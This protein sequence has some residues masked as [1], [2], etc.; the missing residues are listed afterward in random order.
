VA[1]TP[2]N[3]HLSEPTPFADASAPPIRQ[4]AGACTD[5]LVLHFI[6]AATAPNTRRA[7]DS[8][9]KHFLAW[10]GALPASPEDVARYLAA[11]ATTHAVATLARH[12]VAIRRAHAL[13]GLSDP[14]RS[15]LVRLTFRG[16]RRAQARPQRRAAALTVEEIAA[17][18]ASLGDSLRDARD[19]ALLLTGFAGAFRRSE[20]SRIDCESI[21]RTEAGI[22]ITVRRS[23]TDQEGQTRQ[24]AI[25]RGRNGICPVK[26]LDQWLELSGI[27][28]GPVFRPV[29][30][31]G[32]VLPGQLSGDAIAFIVKQR[33][34]SIGL[35]P[36][37]YSGHSLRAGFVTSAATAGAPAWRIKAQTGHASDALVGRYI[38]LSDPFAASSVM[39]IF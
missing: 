28:E 34:K 2:D 39:A 3:L 37:R 19:R 13:Q 17:I 33:A 6:E 29:T 10:G 27:I 22:V 7:Y 24:V 14:V 4:L 12:L 36:T 11:H 20:L 21:E 9:L 8:D 38:R 26:A 15:E 32:H 16:I 31:R 25:P 35:D 23:K 30:R 1:I 5:P 18:M